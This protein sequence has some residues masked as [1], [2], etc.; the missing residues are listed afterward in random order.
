MTLDPGRLE[1]LQR[2]LALYDAWR[3]TDAANRP[4][5]AQFLA[6]HEDL[7]DLLRPLLDDDLGETGTASP[8]A[9]V[10]PVSTDASTASPPPAPCTSSGADPD[11]LGEGDEL[12]GFVIQ[13]EIGRGAM[14][15]VFEARQRSLGRRVAL[16]VLPSSAHVD[17]RTV[18]RF[19]RESAL[20]AGLDHPGLVDVLTVGRDRGL[21]F[22]AMEFVD[23]VPLHAV[24]AKLKGQDPST[25]AGSHFGT[26]VETLV[27]RLEA[28]GATRRARVASGSQATVGELWTRGYLATVIDLAAQVADALHHAHETGLVHRDVKP[29]NI[30]VRADGRAVLADFGLA[31]RIDT[32]SVTRSGEFAGTAFYAAPEQIVRASTELDRR[33]D[34]FA[35]GVTLF[36]L[37][38]LRRP[39][40]GETNHEVARAILSEEPPDP[41][42]LNRRLPDDLAAILLKALEK[43]PERRYP[44]AGALR[45]DLRAFLAFRPVAA[46]RPGTLER[47]RRLVRRRPAESALVAALALGIPAVAGLGGYLLA[48]APAIQ[49]GE[50][51]LRAARIDEIL[52]RAMLEIESRRDPGAAEAIRQALQLDGTHRESRVLEVIALA[53]GG[54]HDAA[55]MA[56]K[57]LAQEDLL[58]PTTDRA[59]QQVLDADANSPTDDPPGDDLMSPG[60]A[61]L[62]GLA[63]IDRG[64]D[65][66]AEQFVTARRWFEEAVLLSPSPRSLYFCQLAHVLGH[67]DDRGASELV[68]RAL[69]HHWPDSPISSYWAAF[70]FKRCDVEQYLARLSQTIPNAESLAHVMHY[71]LGSQLVA[72]GRY[73]AALPALEAAVARDPRHAEAWANLGGTLV[74]LHRDERAL[75]AYEKALTLRP[76]DAMFH[77]NRGAL[78]LRMGRAD[79]G[80]L[81]LEHALELDPDQPQALSNLTRLW[82]QRG[83]YDQAIATCREHIEAGR[84]S[85][86]LHVVWATALRAQGETDEGVAVLEAGVDRHP[87]HPHV[88]TELGNQ[89]AATDPERARDCAQRATTLLPAW[90]AAWNLLG[91][92][93]LASGH[94][95]A[96]LAALRR[97]VD[98]QPGQATPLLDLGIAANRLGQHEVGK[99]AFGA[100]LDSEPRQAQAT[101]GYGKCS[102][103]LGD[104]AS[105]LEV[106]DAM[107]EWAPEHPHL[108]QNRV[109]TFT[110]LDRPADVVAERLR[111][112][113]LAPD[114]AP[115]WKAVH[116]A[117]EALPDDEARTAAAEARAALERLNARNRDDG[118]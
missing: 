38:T 54:E 4:A 8:S 27:V 43:D 50:A 22:F 28:T 79:D 40:D 72:L 17:A 95:D 15:V 104:Y 107:L 42:R 45:D 36:E 114:D 86:F 39:F 61:F 23:G 14:G 69:A 93:E 74:R 12:G 70:A 83:A 37:V 64:H 48:R 92:I 110:R 109:A 108:H 19:R 46:R 62:R 9:A 90:P 112:A 47:L 11:L 33:V 67:L 89:V 60:F 31:R 51:R 111:W 34:V 88:W 68:A 20:L 105:A 103:D 18:A 118:R 26:L 57:Q 91:R 30:L 115:R 25:L 71:Q 113:R 66:D 5:A 99:Q 3:G 78:L 13:R 81:A 49:A 55:R 98:L 63:A 82:L 35:L 87:E 80:E 75:Q 24:V 106:W 101:L 44:T 76:Q 56:A 116:E 59:L 102:F 21:E 6:A 10:P 32:P 16:K 117:A 94:A 53:R 52:Q 65:G 84:S 96:A 97:A 77:A 73:E 41:Q 2:A 1:R 7:A 29:S 100:V 58:D 85:P